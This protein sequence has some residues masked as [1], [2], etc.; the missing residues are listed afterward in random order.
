[1]D[2]A[3][4]AACESCNDLYGGWPNRAAPAQASEGRSVGGQKSESLAVADCP[5]AGEQ[6]PD[7]RQVNPTA[8]EG[9][10]IFNHA[11]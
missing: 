8:G 11:R 7:G 9:S 5:A 4:Q 6:G 2:G 10:E 3:S 1:V